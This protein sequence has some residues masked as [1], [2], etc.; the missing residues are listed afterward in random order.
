VSVANAIGTMQIIPSTGAWVSGVIGRR[1]DLL[2]P[3]DNVTAGVM[4]LRILTREA[5]ER[6]AVAGYYQGLRSVRQHGMFADTKQYVR[7]VL[8]LRRQFG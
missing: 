1:L 2:D 5:G 8:A 4:V 6:N 3:S 7:S